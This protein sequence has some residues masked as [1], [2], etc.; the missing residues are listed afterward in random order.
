MQ[1]KRVIEVWEKG[2]DGAPVTQL[3]V[4]EHISTVFLHQLFEQEAQQPDPQMLL[5]YF[6]TPEKLALL[7]PYVAQEMDAE[8]YDY[9]L[10]AYGIVNH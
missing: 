4:A 3:P 5:G 8:A 2:M 1:I 6:L 10:S 9:I 7:Q